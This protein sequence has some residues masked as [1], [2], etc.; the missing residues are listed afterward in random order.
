MMGNNAVRS[1]YQISEDEL[2]Q[3]QRIQVE[4]ISE[5][6][7]ICKKNG[8]HYNMVCGTMLG[9]IRHGGHIPWD[10]DADIGFLRGEYERFRNACKNVLNPDKYYIQDFRDT[11][12]YRWGYG[13]LRKK[14][15]EFVRLGQ[16]FMPYP[17]GIFIDLMPFDPVPDNKILRKIHFFIHPAQHHISLLQQQLQPQPFLS[18]RQLLSFCYRSS[19]HL[20]D[21][22]AHLW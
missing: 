1:G 20:M 15:T 11:K 3:I 8:I 4:L 16:E 10:D 2:K 19:C 12:G 22:Y 18:F 13:K 5:V 6:D 17:Q 21:K 14:R 9:A 7:R